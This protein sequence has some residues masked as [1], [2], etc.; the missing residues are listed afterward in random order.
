MDTSGRRVVVIGGGY[1][2][3]KVARDLDET[4]DVTMVDGKDAFFHRVASLRASVDPEWTTAPF[5]SY[6]RLLSRGRVLRDKATGVD[7]AGRQVLLRSGLRLSY[8]ALVIATGA[9]YQEPARFT[10][11]TV[12]EAATAFTEHQKQAARAGS[13]LVV[14]GGPSGVELAAELRRTQPGIPVTLAHS[15]SYLLS[16]TQSRRMG[17]R[18]QEYLEQHDVRVRLNTVITSAGAGLIDQ[19]RASYN[20]D[21][22]F[23]TTGTTPNTLWLR[24]AGHGG[25]LNAAGHVRVDDHLRVRGHLDIFA[26]GDVNDVSEAKL[27]PSA[28]AQASAATHNIRAFLNRASRH[29]SQ[30]RPYRPAQLR[31]FSVPFG[32]GA[33]ATLIPV[34]GQGLAVLGHRV[35][36]A[37]KSRNLAVPIVARLLNQP[38]PQGR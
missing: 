25:W 20:A 29:G 30:P 24:L 8:D 3:V 22:V 15:G 21:L 26:V 10:G 11:V 9:D 38:V 7:T 31:I 33:G 18:A 13:V 2:G 12:D 35:T 23:W 16:R 14:G 17:A 28:I 32:P 6:D 5:F 19:T 27:S 34:N 1:A 4:A 36:D 37:I